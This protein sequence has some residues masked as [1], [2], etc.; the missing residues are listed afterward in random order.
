MEHFCHQF[1][2]FDGKINQNK[3]ETC[4]AAYFSWA[5]ITC[6]TDKSEAWLL[7]QVWIT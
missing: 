7:L 5:T 2:V 4:I 6:N 1:N 3:R